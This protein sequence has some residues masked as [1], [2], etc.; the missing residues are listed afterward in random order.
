MK[1]EEAIKHLEIHKAAIAEERDRLS[2]LQEEIVSLLD[3]CERAEENIACAI[4]ALSEL[5]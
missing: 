1:Y 3:S 4:D 2:L 5:V